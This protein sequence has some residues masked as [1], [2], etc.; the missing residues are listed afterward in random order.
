MASRSKS[1]NPQC[2]W[3]E[4]SCYP[5][6]QCLFCVYAI[7]V[8]RGELDAADETYVTWQPWFEQRKIERRGG[9]STKLLKERLATGPGPT[10]GQTAIIAMHSRRLGI[11]P[12]SPTTEDEARDVINDLKGRS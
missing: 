10:K 3:Q 1:P 6:F 4:P 9:A 2:K 12:P 5:D 8:E 7:L 11:D